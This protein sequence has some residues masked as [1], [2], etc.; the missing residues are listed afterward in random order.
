MI[1]SFA[2]LSAVCAMEVEDYYQIG[3]RTWFRLH[4][5]GGKHHE[6]PV[7]HKAEDYVDAYIDATG[8]T[9]KDKKPPSSAPST[10]GVN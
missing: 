8:L 3:K 5:K 1:F 7:H 9:G 6:V 10:A 2:R 4:E